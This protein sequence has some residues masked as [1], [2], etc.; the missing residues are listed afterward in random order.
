[1]QNLVK[2]NK[3]QHGYHHRQMPM[4]LITEEERVVKSSG[5]NPNAPLFIPAALKQVEDFSP[6]WWQL[7]TSSSWYRDYWMTQNQYHDDG[8][9]CDYDHDYD[10][11]VFDMLP[12]GDELFQELVQCYEPQFGLSMVEDETLMKNF[13]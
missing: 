8:F 4:G 13:D 10:D 6:E 2:V 12:D 9:G 7:V 3:Q 5:L 1:M 11:D